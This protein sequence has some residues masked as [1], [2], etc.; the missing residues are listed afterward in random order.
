MIRNILASFG[1]WLARRFGPVRPGE[2][3]KTTDQPVE[4]SK[5][6]EPKQVVLH[7]VFSPPPS[8]G[9]SGCLSPTHQEEKLELHPDSEGNITPEEGAALF[10]QLAALRSMGVVEKVA[11]EQVVKAAI[12]H[13]V[14]VHDWKRPE[15]NLT[16]RAS[17]SFS[18]LG[19]LCDCGA[20]RVYE[21]PAFG[22]KVTEP[23]LVG[24]S[25]SNV[26]PDSTEAK[27]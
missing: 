11:Y 23:L 4:L 25:E 19:Q 10:R 13:P 20:T 9:I 5:T 27:S 24:R 3:P 14:H 15:L 18:I 22:W 12:L 7:Q 26:P 6:T 2:V 17:I 16:N 8:C 21:G 1:M